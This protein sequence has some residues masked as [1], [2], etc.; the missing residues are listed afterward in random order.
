MPKRLLLALVAAAVLGIV[1]GAGAQIDTEPRANLELGVA[2]PLRGDGPLSG[3]GFF[4]WNRPHFPDDDLY[5]RLVIAPTFLMS[6]LVRDRWPAPGHAVGVGASGGLF[7]YNFDEYRLGRH[8]E[9]ESFWGHGGEATLSYYRRLTV[10][11]VLPIEGQLRLRPQYVVYQKAADT[12][13]RFELPPDTMIYSGRGGIRLGGVPPEL[14]P[15][16]ALELSIWYETSYRD[17][18][19]SYGLPE[20]R[21]ELEHLTQRAW[22]RFGGIF[23]VTPA[24]TLSTFA[25][26]GTS[27]DADSLSSFRLGS[28]LRLRSEFPMVL[29][30]Y[31]IDE[32]FA[33][34]FWLVNVSYRLPI[35][36]GTDR[37]SLQLAFDY[38]RVDYL[39]GHALPRHGL[40]GLGADLSIKV[41]KRLTVEFGYGYGLDAPRNG[42]FG[43]HEAHMAL[44]VKLQD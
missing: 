24:Q 21:Q 29:H 20:R 1:G 19:G 34:R 9:R 4:L 41:T 35:W 32:V 39:R 15:D 26:A 7:P 28:S 43:G 13:S 37:L 8:E 17:R 18:A 11:G 36:P 33:R 31:Y 25:T 40:R 16:L 38:A 12:A 30:G 5:F 14:F 27:E 10:L 23:K 6:E 3:Y 44:E 42:G 2:G 22:G